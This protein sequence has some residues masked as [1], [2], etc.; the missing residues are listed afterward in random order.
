MDDTGTDCVK[1]I[2]CTLMLTWKNRTGYRHPEVDKC[3]GGSDGGFYTT[4][5]KTL[6]S[7][8]QRTFQ[9]RGVRLPSTSAEIV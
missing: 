3:A 8:V 2:V 5:Y 1:L 9:F 4:V 7:M 6:C